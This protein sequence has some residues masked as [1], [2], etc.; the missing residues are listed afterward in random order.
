M[1]AQIQVRYSN[2]R[3]LG[4]SID[5]STNKREAG[6]S[7]F[8]ASLWVTGGFREGCSR[9]SAALSRDRQFLWHHRKIADVAACYFAAS[10]RGG[11]SDQRSAAASSAALA[12]TQILPDTFSTCFQNGARVFR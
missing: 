9:L 10:R 4:V 11:G 8:G 5:N 7:R 1:P 12:S 6:R 2:P 3:R